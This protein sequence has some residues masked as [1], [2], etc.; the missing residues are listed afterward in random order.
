MTTMRIVLG[1]VMILLGS[2]VALH[3]LWANGRPITTSIWFDMAFAALFLLRGVM[4][5]RGARRRR[6]PDTLS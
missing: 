4:N 5:V 6:G 1:I 2:Y 3:P